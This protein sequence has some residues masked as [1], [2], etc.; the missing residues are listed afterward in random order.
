MNARHRSGVWATSLPYRRLH[1]RFPNAVY[2]RHSRL[3]PA[4]L[5]LGRLGGSREAPQALRGSLAYWTSARAGTGSPHD[6][7]E[8]QSRS[9]DGCSGSMKPTDGATTLPEHRANP[10]SARSPLSFGVHGSRL[11]IGRAEAPSAPS[12]SLVGAAP[13]IWLRLYSCP[14]LAEQTVVRRWR[15]PNLSM[16][17]A[18][19]S[20]I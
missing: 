15:V 16:R 2:G 13:V 14:R 3:M 8:R 7:T 4:R 17:L 20:M 11:T 6:A 9:E 18:R 5:A 19:R 12:T 1:S 10:R